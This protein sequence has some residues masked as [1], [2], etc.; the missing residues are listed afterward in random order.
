M[1]ARDCSCL[2]LFEV[3]ASLA[4][5]CTEARRSDGLVCTSPYIERPV[6][7]IIIQSFRDHTGRAAG[8]P[9]QLTE[10]LHAIPITKEIVVNDDAQGEGSAAWIP[11]LRGPN[12]FYISSPNLHEPRAYNRLASMMRGEFLVLVQ[13]DACLP[14]SS[15]WMQDALAILRT[16][17][18]L[19]MLSGRMG[20]Y[21]VL[22]RAA[23]GTN[24]NQDYR[25][26]RM[27]GEMPSLPIKHQLLVRRN[28]SATSIGA[29]QISTEGDG[30]RRIPFMFMAGV[31]NG[32]L[33]F[34]RDA[35]LSLGGFD[36]GYGCAVLGIGGGENVDDASSFGFERQLASS[37]RCEVHA[38]DSSSY[39]HKL[40]H[41]SPEV[42]ERAESV[43]KVSPTLDSDL[44]VQFHEAFAS[45]LSA[46]STRTGAPLLITHLPRIIE[47]YAGK[48]DIDILKIDCRGCEWSLFNKLIRRRKTLQPRVK[49]LLLRI[50]LCRLPTEKGA[51]SVAVLAFQAVMSYLVIDN[52]F[53][54]FSWKH[55]PS[56]RHPTTTRGK[57]PHGSSASSIEVPPELVMAGLPRDVCRYQLQFTR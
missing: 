34:R 16:L 7:S 47:L 5:P 31:D 44:R 33:I 8:Q 48:R 50:D 24:V 19:A 27:R 12:D 42:R 23:P 36:E 20:F 28:D 45:R 11:R 49:L 53:K 26:Q 56:I 6:L 4:S 41:S 46:T 39:W 2:L 1:H 3:V 21:E 15:S 14:N 18:K 30:G 38:I 29:S 55:L 54:L 32:P 57:V 37:F 13:G 35:L 17:P 43:I 9:Q 40:V 22:T 52:S 25:R 51:S 10:K